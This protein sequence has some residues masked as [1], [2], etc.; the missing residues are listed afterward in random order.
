MA[1]QRSYSI[2]SVEFEVT[3]RPAM[4]GSGSTEIDVR[5]RGFWPIAHRIKQRRSF[6]NENIAYD[7][8]PSLS[9]PPVEFE[10]TAR[11]AMRG[12]GSTEINV[13]ERRFRPI[14]HRIKQRRSFMNENIA[15]DE[16]P[17]LSLPPVEFEVTARPAMRGSGSTEINIR[18]AAIQQ[19]HL[20]IQSFMNENIANDKCIL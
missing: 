12:S 2:P 7:E 18:E 6:M 13:R 8:R 20:C 4:R 3:A 9:L 17:S 14:A 11:P 16:R 10:V 19:R 1:E 5:E 15:Y